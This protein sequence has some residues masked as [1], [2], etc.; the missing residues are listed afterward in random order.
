MEDKKVM[1]FINEQ[2]DELYAKDQKKN[3]KKRKL[4]VLTNILFVAAVVG[5]LFVF[6]QSIKND[7]KVAIENC[8][9]EG[10]SYNY[11]LKDV[12]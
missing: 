10:H 5:I 9:R 11:C 7:T 6:I 8:I 3:R 12:Q 4:E 1:E 2:H